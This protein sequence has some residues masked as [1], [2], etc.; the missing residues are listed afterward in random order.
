MEAQRY[1]LSVVIVSGG[2][3]GVDLWAEKKA[4]QQGMRLEVYVPKKGQLPLGRNTTIAEKA[5]VCLALPGSGG[6]AR[7]TIR[8]FKVMDKPCYVC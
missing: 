2:A 1:N 7:D 5:D 8:K 6:G 3:I 4:R